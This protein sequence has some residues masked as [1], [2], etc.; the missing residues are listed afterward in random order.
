MAEFVRRLLGG[1]VGRQLWRYA[2]VGLLTNAA[3]YS[4]Y[5]LLTMALGVAP[6]LAMTVLYLVGATAGFFGHRRVTFAYQGGHLGAGAR[7]ALAHLAGYGI[8]LVLLQVGVESLGMA[9]Q[10]V[11]AIAVFV[12]AAFLF[13]TFKLFVFPS[14]GSTQRQPSLGTLPAADGSD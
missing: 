6:K 14:S 10:I 4:V 2:M 5:L 12:V 8:N 1:M 7:Y 9:H 13:V 3:G 11:Q